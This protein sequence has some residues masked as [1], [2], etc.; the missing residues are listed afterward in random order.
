MEV[1]VYFAVDLC[2]DCGVCYWFCG[3]WLFVVSVVSF[4]VG[5]E[6]GVVC[7]AFLWCCFW[8]WC[9]VV[10]WCCVWCGFG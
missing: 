2:A 3:S 8:A 6:C 4:V 5:E 9:F 10:E 7:V 1:L